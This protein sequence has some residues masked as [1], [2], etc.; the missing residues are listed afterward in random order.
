MSQNVVK[1]IVLTTIICYI[2]HWINLIFNNYQL[3][4]KGL[5]EAVIAHWPAIGGSSV[6]GLRGNWLFRDGLLY[7]QDDRWELV[8]EKSAYD[9]LLDKSPFSFSIIKYP[10]MSKPLHV[11]CPY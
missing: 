2:N 7:D 5:I 11:T 9:L 1:I 6:E 10:W 4:I 3:L 8:V